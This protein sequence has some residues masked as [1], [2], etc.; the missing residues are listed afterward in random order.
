MPRSQALQTGGQGL[1]RDL[2]GTVD[3]DLVTKATYRNRL[4]IP[5]SLHLPLGAIRRDFS[6]ISIYCLVRRT[7]IAS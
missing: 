3:S 1:A 7:F 2:R 5:K 6:H 4:E